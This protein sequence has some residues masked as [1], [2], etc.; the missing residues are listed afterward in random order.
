MRTLFALMLASLLTVAV[1]CQNKDGTATNNSTN[2]SNKTEMTSADACS[3]CEGKQI[4]TV[5]GKCPK[6]GMKVTAA[7]K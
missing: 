7:A 5:D 4:A 1:G 6:C 3:H 2:N